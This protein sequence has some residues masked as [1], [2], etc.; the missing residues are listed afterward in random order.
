MVKPNDE[1]QFLD[2]LDDGVNADITKEDGVYSRYYIKPTQQGRYTF[3]CQVN[4]SHSSFEKLG[5]IGSANPKF[6]GIINYF[7]R[8]YL[9]Q[10]IC[11]KYYVCVNR[12]S[13][14]SDG[15]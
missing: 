8:N 15:N 2:L 4:G 5:F 9:S 14:K 6:L 12:T 10:Y 13:S 3:K 11:K 1:Y 7:S